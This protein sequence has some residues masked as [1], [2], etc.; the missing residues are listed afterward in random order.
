MPPNCSETALQLALM[1]GHGCVAEALLTYCA[2]PWA[3]NLEDS[4][5]LL[6]SAVQLDSSMTFEKLIRSHP[7]KEIIFHESLND[8][9]YTVLRVAIQAGKIDFVNAIVNECQ[10]TESRHKLIKL[11]S[12][13]DG[14]A[15]IHVAAHCCETKIATFLITCC[16]ACVDI[17]DFS[18]RTPLHLA[19]KAG[20]LDTVKVLVNA[21]ADPRVVDLDN[22]NPAQCAVLA[23]SNADSNG[24]AS[25]LG[26]LFM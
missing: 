10:S 23:D 17:R 24:I 5:G 20:C 14:W 7:N 4:R 13:S 18:K 3:D 21:K 26:K 6:H 1:N 25:Y 22:T 11:G 8:N 2:E 16:P 9:R 19:A 12:G 15:A